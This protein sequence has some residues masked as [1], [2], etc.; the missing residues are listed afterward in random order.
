MG[1]LLSDRQTPIY[2]ARSI[3][4]HQN[5]LP[6]GLLR[7]PLVGFLSPV[8]GSRVQDRHRVSRGYYPKYAAYF[9]PLVITGIETHAEIL[10]SYVSVQGYTSDTSTHRLPP[11]SSLYTP[12]DPTPL[13]WVW[14]FAPYGSLLYHY[15]SYLLPWSST[16]AIPSLNTEVTH[17]VRC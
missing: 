7:N 11:R 10:H 9:I 13:Y 2:P 14:C 15:S 8:K 1:F 5:S 4:S 17:H 16:P 3:P 12:S 6:H